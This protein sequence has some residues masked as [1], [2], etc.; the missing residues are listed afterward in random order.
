MRKQRRRQRQK[1]RAQ[2]VYHG[3]TGKTAIV[4]CGMKLYKKRLYY[5]NYRHTPIYYTYIQTYTCAHRSFIFF[6]H[7]HIDL[8]KKTVVVVNVWRRLGWLAVVCLEPFFYI[9]GQH[10]NLKTLFVSFR[11]ISFLLFSFSSTFFLFFF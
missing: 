8:K 3:N 4:W 9:I 11:F 2:V 5:T 10:W 1:Q 6:F 7:A